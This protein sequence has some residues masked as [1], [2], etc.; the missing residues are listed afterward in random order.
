MHNP[1]EDIVAQIADFPTLPTVYSRLLEVISEPES[2]VEEIAKIILNDP[3]SSAK[4]LRTVNSSVFGLQRQIDTIS[5][6]IF[7]VGFNEVKNL[8]MALSVIDIF[9]NTASIQNLTALDLWKHSIAVGVITRILGKHANIKNI[10][11]YYIAGML[12]DIGKLFLMK[13]F[14]DDYSKVVK[15]VYESEVSITVAERDIFQIDHAEVGS[16]IANKWKLPE[17]I[18]NTIKYHESGQIEAGADPVVAYVN[19]A[20]S[21]AIML[22]LG[23]SGELNI[24]KPK[25]EI[26]KHINIKPELL[27]SLNNEIKTD[28]EAAVSILLLAN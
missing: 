12:H 25:A 11:N 24:P 21:I 5:E 13:V 22:E 16:L 19:L 28:F 2:T 17:T 23:D 27:T 8:V 10:E 7:H 9:Q 6:A 1:L 14:R 3:A 26:W 20:N 18:L 4:I 15:E